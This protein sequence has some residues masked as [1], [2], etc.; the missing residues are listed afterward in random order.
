MTYTQVNT[1]Y[2]GFNSLLPQKEEVYSAL[3]KI[4]TAV[5]QL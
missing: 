5:K 3:Q 1:V 2:S 4:K